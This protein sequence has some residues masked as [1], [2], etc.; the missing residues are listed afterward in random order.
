MELIENALQACL[1]TIRTYEFY[2]GYINVLQ[3]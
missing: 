3:L 2:K 1:W